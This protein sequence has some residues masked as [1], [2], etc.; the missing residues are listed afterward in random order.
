MNAPPITLCLQFLLDIILNRFFLL[1]QFDIL[2]IAMYNVV[3]DPSEKK[4]M[5]FDL[6]EIF[7]K[8]RSR[9]I[10]HLKNVVPADFPPPDLSGHPGNFQGFFSPGWC[11]PRYSYIMFLTLTSVSSK[12]EKYSLLT[13][14]LKFLFMH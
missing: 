14:M 3:E 8:L 10:F 4:D 7:A 2:D 9:A 13:V 1:L 12:V 5:K 6:S 11:Q